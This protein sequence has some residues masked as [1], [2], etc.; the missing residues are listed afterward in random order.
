VGNP[1]KILLLSLAFTILWVSPAG[2]LFYPIGDLNGDRNVNYKDLWILA[3]QWL[4]EN[5]SV[6]GCEADLDG[7]NGVNMVDFSML[8]NN[9]Q[10]QGVTLL[11]SEFMASNGSKLPLREGDLLDENGDSSDW[12]EIYNPTDKSINLNGW[13]L[14]NNDGNE[15]KEWEFPATELKPGEFL[16]VFASGKDRA[17]AGYELHTNFVLGADGDYLALAKSDGVTIAHEYAPEYPKQLTNISYGL[18]QDANTFVDSG[19]TVSYHVPTASDAQ[20]NWTTVGFND[21]SWD[22]AKTGLGFGLVQADLID[23]TNPGDVVQGVPNDGDWPAGESPPNT[24]DDNVSTK[25]LHFKGY[26]GT[27]GFRVTP[28]ESQTIVTGLTFTTA[29]DWA[30]RDPIAYALSGSNVSI[31]GPYTLIAAGEI[32][33]FKQLTEWPRFTKNTTP[34]SFANT[35]PYNHY[36]IIFTA[37]R[38]PAAVVHM[39]IAEVEFL[40]SPAGPISNIQGQML[41]K[42]A[43]LWVRAKFNLTAEDIQVFNILTLSM[44]YEDGFVAYLNGVEVTRR[45]FSGTPRWDSHA[46]SNRPNDYAKD[47]ENIDISNYIDLLR[48]GTNVLAIHALNDSFADLN[49]LILPELVAGSTMRMDIWQYFAKPTPGKLNISGAIDLVADTK[50]SYDRGF[51]DAPFDV[52]ITTQT[53]GATIHYT[54]NGSTPSEVDGNE[55]TGP[56]PIRTTTCLRAMAFKPGWISTNV[57]T[58]TYIFLDQ[59]IRQPASPAGF[60]TSWVSTTADY[61]MD[62]R[63]VNDTRYKGL[64]RDSLLSIPT[65]SIVTDVNNL[66]GT[67]GIYSNS[68][69]AGVA[70]E[71]PASIEWICPDGTTGFHV[72]AGLR[73]YGGDPFRGMSLTRKKSFR[74]LFKRQYG[75]TKLDF[76]LFDTQDAATSFDTIV[77]RA[78]AND[79]WNNWTGSGN[80]PNVQYILDE[81]IRRTQLALGQ[82]SPHGTF[83]HLYIN[84]LYWGLYNPVERPMASFCATYYGGDEEEWDAL[85]SGTPTGESSTTT[86]NAMMS[87]ASAG[88]S[89][90]TAYQKIQGNNP[91]GTKNPAY[92]DLLDIEN[93]ID[94]LFSNFWGGT[95]DWPYH[96]FYVGCRRPPNTTGFKFFD[97]DA[98]YVIVIGSGLNSNVTG[99]S[100][101]GARPYVTL[102]QN[103]E[104]RL[105]FADHAHRHLFNSGPAITEASYA[106]YKELADQVE[107]AIISE[108]ARWGDMGYSTPFT[109]ADWQKTRDYILGTYMPQRPAIVLQQLR[110][111][112]LYPN[113]AAPVFYINGSYKHG[114]QVAKTDQLSMQNPN[115]SGKIYYTKD[116]ND[117]RLPTPSQ[118]GTNVT[119]VTETAAK[120]VLIPASAVSDAWKGGSEPFDDSLWNDATFVSGKTGGVGYETSS[121][122]ENYI[123]YDVKAKMYNIRDTCY[124][125]IPFTFTG[126]LIELNFMTLKV[127][128]DDGFVAYLNGTKVAGRNFPDPPAWNSSASGTNPDSAAIQFENIDISSYLGVLR[129]GNNILAI[130]GL[131]NA[132]NRSDFLISVELVAGKGSA[133]LSPSAIEYT[134]PITLD[135]STVVKAR[136]LSGNTWSALNEAT[137]AVGPVKD[138]LRITEIMYHPADTGDPNDPNK[139]FIELKNIGTETLNLNLMRF[140]EG[141]HITFPPWE[142]AAGEYVVVVRDL[143]VFEDQYGTDVNIAGQYSGSLD[144]AGERIRL[145][146]AVGQMIL[147]FAYKDGWRDITDGDGFSLTIINPADPN[148]N[149]WGEKENWRASALYG[150][151]PGE[152]DSGI[153]PNPG[154]VVINEILAHSHAGQPDWI[155]LHNT[156]DHPINIGG[157]FLSDDDA[158]PAR[159]KI[160]SDT[161]IDRYGYVIFYEDTNFADPNDPSCLEVFRLSENGEEVCLSSAQ[162]DVLTG[163]QEIQNFGASET[164]VSFGRY[165]KASINNIDFVAMSENTP[166][167]A[168]AYPKIGPI[169]INEIMY[170]PPSGSDAEF[171][172]LR[173]ITGNKVDLFDIEGNTWK[174]NDEEYGIDCNLPAN[175]SILANGYLLLVKNESVFQSRY[176]GVPGGVQILQWGNGKLNNGGEKIY[177]SMPGDVNHGERHYIRVDMINYDNKAPWPLEP[178]GGGAS[179]SRLSPQLYGNDPNNWAAQ[180][181]SPGTAN[182]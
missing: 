60:P 155:E 5:C 41:N 181:P 97:W 12:I 31:N 56:I 169:V 72:N 85:N 182:P 123:S 25:Y 119:L 29:N 28:S 44:M 47:F 135:K 95:A 91:D 161:V 109:L 104:F 92:D 117:P 55:Y 2:A 50:F 14:L 150:G 114:G 120:R 148:I 144:N 9:W 79:A 154:D 157:W 63:V 75:P 129:S 52:I 89:D 160:A 23:V 34:I 40:G 62:Q 43:S 59:V 36:Q 146:D 54:T 15:I 145:E 24:I 87:Q 163:Y 93:Y 4:N 77:L 22:T 140:T 13:Y 35:T 19:A 71:R 68:T 48:Q 74:L 136:V 30:Q 51:Y 132:G 42:N 180:T 134:T 81:F 17:V 170:N 172:E 107:L 116:G 1:I 143:G 78:G 115:A 141:I 20:T 168:N 84:G 126:N 108:S 11:I 118:Q 147:D 45:N 86:W 175:T 39:Q 159:Y 70:W 46:D 176:P 6:A 37:I 7:A 27:T 122:Y 53:E 164:G 82:V 76:P 16:I 139:E 10:T 165:F 106:R 131:N 65:V 64:M 127:R 121:G 96:N 57:D 61:A 90:N 38:D 102:R 138:K 18:L 8:A 66:F 58:Q 124:I 105:L 67:S 32:V 162:G 49:F 179:L 177:I 113:V 130:H 111:A 149:H 101:N 69:L 151:S 99:V 110:S 171:V 128:Y 83:V 21:G 166:G 100:D 94:W 3:E 73:I 103:D 153:I 33:D 133:I 178:D 125:R 88:L 112:G 167:W 174:F 26:T 98:E 152:D 173:N 80:G 137:Y 156:T 142:L 158:Y